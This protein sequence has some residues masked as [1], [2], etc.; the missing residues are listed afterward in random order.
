MKFEKLLP[1]IS[2]LELT[3]SNIVAISGVS[4]EEFGCFYSLFAKSPF[5]VFKMPQDVAQVSQGGLFS[6]DKT[7][8]V[9]FGE[10]LKKNDLSYI[11]DV[12]QSIQ[13]PLFIVAC[14]KTIIEPFYL[15]LKNQMIWLDLSQEKPW[16]KKDRQLVVL[17]AKAKK[18][19][20]TLDK[21][22]AEA[23]LNFENDDLAQACMRL[24]T[25]SL[26]AGDAKKITH[27]MI[28]ELCV[29]QAKPIDFAWVDDLVFKTNDLEKKQINDPQEL[30]LFLGQLRYIV[31]TAL[32]IKAVLA[33]GGGQKQIQAVFPKMSQ[34]ALGY[35]LK[36]AEEFSFEQLECLSRILYEKEKELKADFAQPQGI[37]LDLILKIRQMKMELL[38][39]LHA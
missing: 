9:T 34:T 11:Q 28:E 30:L 29:K 25:L 13:N 15:T 3:H 2:N 16:E 32:K 38:A 35:Q 31:T 7:W 4:E 39:N 18:M 27:K 23:L 8:V 12:L 26:Y 19:Q 24:E 6:D 14:S 36:K 10:K 22:Q 20:V 17:Q 21:N 1:F 37:F 33:Q 5:A